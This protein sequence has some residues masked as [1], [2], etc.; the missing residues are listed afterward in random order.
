MA[1]KHPEKDILTPA[2]ATSEIPCC[3]PILSFQTHLGLLASR[4]V[5]HAQLHYA[6]P[7]APTSALP[8]AHSNLVIVLYL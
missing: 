1:S 2:S 8:S 5:K 6:L 4:N 3:A 7:P